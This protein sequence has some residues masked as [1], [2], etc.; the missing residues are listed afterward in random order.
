MFVCK[1]VHE[2]VEIDGLNRLVEVQRKEVVGAY[3]T[4][5]NFE[6]FVAAG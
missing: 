2:V 6:S 4:R 5:T 3:M 1:F